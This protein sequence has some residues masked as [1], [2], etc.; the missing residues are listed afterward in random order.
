VAARD[1]FGMSSSCR[2]A[3]RGKFL[4]PGA[5]EASRE[6]GGDNPSSR[7]ESPSITVSESE[8]LPRSE[9][10]TLADVFAA[11]D[12][13]W[14]RRG[15]DRDEE[16]LGDWMGERMRYRPDEFIT[17]V[18]RGWLGWAAAG[19]RR[20]NRPRR[21]EYAARERWREGTA[22]SLEEVECGC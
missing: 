7:P 21:A 13:P 17:A 3:N 14:E 15:R 1:W 19:E 2:P 18:R 16:R 5:I 20:Q 9:V 22:W 4:F 10:S 11:S 12:T 6:W 8:S